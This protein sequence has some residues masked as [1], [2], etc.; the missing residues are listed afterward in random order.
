M[1]LTSLFE[2]DIL[3]LNCYKGQKGTNQMKCPY[4]N[5]PDTRVI[6]SRPAEDGSCIRRRRSCD[7]CGKRFTTYEK[8]ETIPLTVIKKDNTREQYDRRKVEN[9]MFVPVIND[10]LQRQIS[11]KLSTE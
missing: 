4:C 6:D 7:I 9:G 1:C 8:V 5:N 3:Y 11:R 10:L 2:K